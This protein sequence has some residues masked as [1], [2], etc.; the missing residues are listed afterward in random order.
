MEQALPELLTRYDTFI[1]DSSL[2]L[3]S[4][5]G[6]FYPG[7]ETTLSRLIEQHKQV[8]VFINHP[9]PPEACF[10]ESFWQPWIERGVRF[11]TSGGIC[12]KLLAEQ[13]Y[14]SYFL[15]GGRLLPGMI[16]APEITMAE[17]AAA[18]ISAGRKFNPHAGISPAWFCRRHNAVCSASARGSRTE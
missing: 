9:L 17:C 14:F 2:T 10:K 1:L 16:F 15:F 6:G 8:I 13:G 12:L 5:S 7:V 18:G 11:F 3:I 4:P